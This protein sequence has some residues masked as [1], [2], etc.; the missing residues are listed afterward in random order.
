MSFPGVV[1]S[2]R[3]FVEY[4]LNIGLRSFSFTDF[5]SRLDMELF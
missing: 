5:E 3:K 4:A 2:E 1:D